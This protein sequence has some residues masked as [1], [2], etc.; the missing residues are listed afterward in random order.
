MVLQ[1]AHELGAVGYKEWGG[2][3]VTKSLG[4][5][6]D[7]AKLL[8]HFEKHGAEFGAKSA[9]EYLLIAR[10]VMKNGTK[11]QYEYRGEVRTGFV[12]LM[13]NTGKGQSKFAFV[14]TNSQGQITTL[15]TK[16]G[17][18]FWKT[19]NGNPQDKTIY[20]VQE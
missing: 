14:G 8:S 17:K 12:K 11:I 1:T 6:A 15:H 7:Q 13:G 9:D 19:L 2:K 20:P 4:S 10:D 3:A 16:S 5:F 18:D